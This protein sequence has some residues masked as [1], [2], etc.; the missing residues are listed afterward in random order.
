MRVVRNNLDP[1]LAVFD[2]PVPSSARGRRDATNVPAQALAMM[3]SP[4]VAGWAADWARRVKADPRWADDDARV[5][6]LFL[7]AFGRP[8]SD[9]E[10][11]ESLDFLGTSGLEALAHALVNAKEFLYVR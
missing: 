1:F 6:R 8:P 7:E 2:F 3:N 11:R 5:R 9:D 4:R 10:R